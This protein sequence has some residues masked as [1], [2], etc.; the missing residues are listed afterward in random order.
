VAPDR[1][2]LSAVSLTSPYNIFVDVENDYLYVPSMDSASSPSGIQVFH[3]ASSLRSGS[4]AP[5]R[6]ITGPGIVNPEAVFL[7]KANNRLY[8]ANGGASDCFIA[9]FDNASSLNGNVGPARAFT[10]PQLSP[11]LH[12]VVVD[13]SRNILYAGVSSGKMLAVYKNAATL[14]GTVTPDAAISG[15]GYIHGL[16]VDAQKDVL[17]AADSPGSMAGSGRILVFEN[18]SQLTAASAPTR[19]ITNLTGPSGL[20]GTSN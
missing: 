15:L 19:T 6:R 13:P 5:T 14:N 4:N 17:F 16:W 2:I 12:D 18:A 1:E 3:G 11:Y 7:D 8:V 20:W 10:S 9:V